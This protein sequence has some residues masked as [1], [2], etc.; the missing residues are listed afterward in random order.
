MTRA[1]PGT[2]RTCLIL[3]ALLALSLVCGVALGPVRIPL[4][5]VLALLRAAV[6]GDTIDVSQAGAYRIVWDI[7]L[8]RVLL[9]A[10][11]GAGLSTVGVAV[12]ALVRNP[13]ADPYVL[14]ISSGASVGATAVAAFGLFASLGIYALSTAA[15]LSALA[16]MALVYLVARSLTP[17]RLVLT[18]TAMAYGFSAI[19][20]LLVF[21]APRGEAARSAM[22]WLLGSLGG[23]TWAALPVA[24]VTTAAGIAF[25]L[26]KARVLNA[27]AMGD[28][29]ATTLGVD[30]TRLRRGLFVVTAAMTGVLV[31]VSGA[32]G[33]VGL[34]LPHVVRLLVGADHRRVLVVA[35]LAG[36]CFLVW[37]DVAARLL[38]APEELPLGVI[39]AALGVPCFVLLM[40]RRGYV[41]GGR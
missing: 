9:A 27:L 22:F 29:A 17:L 1:A 21:Q 36:A 35:P 15:F 5:D 25:L 11:V 39:T 16:A 40:R 32:V 33:F 18:G 2:A 31:A 24:A 20:M 41:F 26:G 19:A 14:G 23:V 34:V 30:V 28:E 37:V 38:A 7:R 4:P 10:V 6:V 3:T 13:L 12:Q 8:P